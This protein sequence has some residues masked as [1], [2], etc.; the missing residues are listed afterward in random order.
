MNLFFDDGLAASA[1]FI[2]VLCDGKTLTTCGPRMYCDLLVLVRLIK[3]FCP[4]YSSLSFFL[5]RS[6]YLYTCY[7]IWMR[8]CHLRALRNRVVNE[9][10][11]DGRVRAPESRPEQLTLAPERFTAGE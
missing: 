4:L 9:F 7:S 3:F 5:S 10:D 8:V 1:V 2:S 6:F 11:R